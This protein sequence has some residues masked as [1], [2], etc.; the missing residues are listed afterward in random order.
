MDEIL[1]KFRNPTRNPGQFTDFQQNSIWIRLNMMDILWDSASSRCIWWDTFCATENT[2][3]VVHFA[4]ISWDFHHWSGGIYVIV[5][6]NGDVVRMVSRVWVSHQSRA[7]FP[8]KSCDWNWEVS[9]RIFFLEFLEYE[10]CLVCSDNWYSNST[11]PWC[12]EAQTRCQE[13]WCGWGG[14]WSW[15][16]RAGILFQHGEFH[17]A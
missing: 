5:V 9:G 12:H 14:S 10:F 16:F 13:G 7:N 8:V 11:W 4:I 2:L 6:W 3:E 15:G 1:I 17:K